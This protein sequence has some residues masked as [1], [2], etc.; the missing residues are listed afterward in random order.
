MNI[1]KYIYYHVYIAHEVYLENVI[2]IAVK[3][4]GNIEQC[5]NGFGMTDG[6]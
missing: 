6:V 2:K 3:E 4:H 1:K 5:C